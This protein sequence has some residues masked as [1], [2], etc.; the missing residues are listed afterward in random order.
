VPQLQLR[1]LMDPVTQVASNDS[2]RGE[3]AV[4]RFAWYAVHTNYQ[5]EK[6]V[7]RILS[8]KGFDIFLPL[9]DVAHRWKDRTK[10]LS[11]PLFP[12]YVFIQG[13]LDRR[14][15]VLNTPGVC[16]FVGWS[17]R[18]APIPKEEIEAVLRMMESS[19]K[20]E[21]HPFLKCGDRVRIRS[22]PLEG[23]EGI[24][25]RKKNL[26][27]LVLSVEM[28]QKSVAVEVDVTAVESVSKLGVAR[29][30]TPSVVAEANGRPWAVAHEALFRTGCKS[31]VT[32]RPESQ[33]G[34]G[35]QECQEMAV[36]VER[37][38]APS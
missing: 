15:H 33:S 32:R 12:C 28:L 26:F 29:A 11:L 35:F 4:A 21:P 37:V 36:V 8:Q 14:L 22:G 24:L 19:L 17:G 1:G 23:V 31:I 3:Y 16:G 7:A 27:R 6:A 34:S 38:A 18:A 10:Q 13:G 9:Y 5:H 20:V 30:H 25:V 2:R